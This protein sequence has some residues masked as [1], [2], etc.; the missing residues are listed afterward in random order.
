MFVLV[1]LKYSCCFCPGFLSFPSEEIEVDKGK[2]PYSNLSQ[3]ATERA[4][5][6]GHLDCTHLNLIHA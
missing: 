4:Q 2:V 5:C 1:S 6:S 3:S